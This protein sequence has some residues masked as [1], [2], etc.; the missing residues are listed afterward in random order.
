MTIFEWMDDLNAQLM[1]Y[2]WDRAYDRGIT[3][4]QAIHEMANRRVVRQR[5]PNYTPN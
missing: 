4:E 5:L 3:P 1:C 2:D